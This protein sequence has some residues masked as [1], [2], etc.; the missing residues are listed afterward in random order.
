MIIRKITIKDAAV[1]LDLM[2]QLIDDHAKLDPYY[3]KFSDYA[4]LPQYIA[5][6][7]KDRDK[8]FLVAESNGKVIAY[9]IGAIEEAPY[10]SSEK[11][12]GVIAD[13]VVDKKHRRSG[14]LK[15]F[16]AEAL[17]WFRK[18]GVHFIELSVDIRNSGAVSAWKKLGFADYKLRMRYDR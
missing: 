12:I 18:K 3:K 11:K 2:K 9:F 14:V 6:T 13:T 16:F 4:E 1:V 8:I 7:A 15:R 17:V 5:D 10:Y